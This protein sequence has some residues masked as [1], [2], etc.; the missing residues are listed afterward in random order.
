MFSYFDDSVNHISETM[1]HELAD[2]YAYAYDIPEDDKELV[3]RHT[4]ADNFLSLP[5]D[6]IYWMYAV[7]ILEDIVEDDDG[8]RADDYMSS[9]IALE[10]ILGKNTA[11][12]SK[13]FALAYARAQLILSCPE[14]YCP[15][16]IDKQYVR[17]AADELAGG[18]DDWDTCEQLG[19]AEQTIWLNLHI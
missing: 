12:T 19:K 17:D 4:A 11:I 5:S 14:S 1:L 10:G 3:A 2:E 6:F 16:I 15:G 13:P 7:A 18:S 8:Y 9:R